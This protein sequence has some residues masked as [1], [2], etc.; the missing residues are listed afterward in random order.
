[1]NNLAT[2]IFRA[3]AML[4]IAT[5]LASCDNGSSTTN[6][7]KQLQ[8]QNAKLQKKVDDLQ[9]N[10]ANL[11]SSQGYLVMSTGIAATAAVVLFCV[12]L[13]VGIRIRARITQHEHQPAGDAN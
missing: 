12:G 9:T 2:T 10:I 11:K 3:F 7:N 13:A 6:Q 1:M 5:T 4:C 8:E